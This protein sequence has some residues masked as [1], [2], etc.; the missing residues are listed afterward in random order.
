MLV[1]LTGVRVILTTAATTAATTTIP[2]PPSPSPSAA[3]V[4]VT[5]PSSPSSPSPSLFYIIEGE[6]FLYER[7]SHERTN[8]ITC[9]IYYSDNATDTLRVCE[10][11]HHTSNEYCDI[12]R[13]FARAVLKYQRIMMKAYDI[14]RKLLMF[15]ITNREMKEE[16]GGGEGGEEAKTVIEEMM[17][18]KEEERKE[19]GKKGEEEEGGEEVIRKDQEG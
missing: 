19:K 14:S 6:G 5:P 4:S 1:P 9:T 13:D 2:P 16:E 3:V 10:S 7:R 11:Y 12:C 15:K 17:K 8:M 18:E